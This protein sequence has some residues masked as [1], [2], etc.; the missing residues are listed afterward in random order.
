MPKHK[1]R[2][3]KQEA[4]KRRE[5]FAASAQTFSY[6]PTTSHASPHKPTHVSSDSIHTTGYEYLLRDLRKTLIVTVVIVTIE[7]VLYFG[8]IGHLFR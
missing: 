3:Q 2:K 5:S 8:N 6:T 4:D 7:L 1:T